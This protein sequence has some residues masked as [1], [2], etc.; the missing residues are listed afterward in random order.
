LGISQRPHRTPLLAAASPSPRSETTTDFRRLPRSFDLA[1]CLSFR[2]Q[3]TVAP[4][5]TISFAGE[6]IQLPAT[7]QSQRSYAGT[8]VELSHQLDGEQ[9]GVTF[10][11]CS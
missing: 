7:S 10:Y 2:Y 9:D 6:D 11:R 8:L 1:R 5:H 3:R 4:D